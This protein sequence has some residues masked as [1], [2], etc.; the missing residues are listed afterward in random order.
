MNLYDPTLAELL[1]WYKD[2]GVSAPMTDGPI[3]QF[4][5]SKAK[6]PAPAQKSVITELPKDAQHKVSKPIS[7]PSVTAPLVANAPTVPDE[8]VIQTAKDLAG[9]ANT[10]E[11]LR[12]VLNDFDGCNLKPAARNT[13]FSDG[14]AGS[15][16]MVIGDA[17][18]ID[19]DKQGVPFAGKSGQ[20]F[21]KMME[22]IG[23][24]RNT[25][26]LTTIIPWRPPG[27]RAPSPQETEICRPFIERHIELAKPEILMVMGGLSAKIL[28]ST[29]KGILSLRG[30]WTDISIGGQTY[31]VLPTLHPSYLLR[32]AEQK[33]MS[34]QDLLM[35]KKKLDDESK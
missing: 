9:S 34:W 20:L 21:N 17:P 3:D 23:L 13:V 1:N 10:L 27:N 19:E 29:A 7:A 4:E 24:D 2:A 12:Q 6:S 28:L 31:P 33:R 14:A 5:L 15:P 35:V 25:I 22:A 18:D 32:Q 16:L 11:E 30:R 26:Y 8:S